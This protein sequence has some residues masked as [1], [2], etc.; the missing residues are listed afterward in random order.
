MC[1]VYH[2]CVYCISLYRIWQVVALTTQTLGL[3]VMRLKMT[4]NCDRLQYHP[5]TAWGTLICVYDFLSTPVVGCFFGTPDCAIN[6]LIS[7]RYQCLDRQSELASALF[8]SFYCLAVSNEVLSVAA[9]PTCPN[10]RFF[11]RLISFSLLTSDSKWFLSDSLVWN[12]SLP[13]ADKSLKVK[14]TTLTK[15]SEVNH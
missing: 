10:S 12:K 14:V 8:S 3:R 13:Q 1:A 2:T 4:K 7:E 5:A 6:R 15:N 11:W 9:R